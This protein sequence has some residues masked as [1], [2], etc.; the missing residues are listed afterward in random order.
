ERYILQIP[1]KFCQRSRRPCFGSR[2]RR[3]K[4]IAGYNGK[5]TGKIFTST[6]SRCEEGKGMDI[7]GQ[8]SE[9]E[10]I[11]EFLKAEINSPRFRDEVIA[12]LN[13]I[14]DKL[15]T[16]PNLHSDMENRLRKEI[17]GKVRGYGPNRDLFEN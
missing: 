1:E 3:F 15:I 14:D 12:A 16:Q 7:I 17:L 11:A 13:G 10:V 5:P 8:I 4:G 9:D 2:L 6:E